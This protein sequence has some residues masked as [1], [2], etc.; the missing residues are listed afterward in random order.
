MGTRFTL[1]RFYLTRSYSCH[2]TASDLNHP[3]CLMFFNSFVLWFR[4][5]KL[6]T[7]RFQEVSFFVLFSLGIKDDLAFAIYRLSR[8]DESIRGRQAILISRDM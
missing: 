2:G 4:C 7:E 1:L 3:L 5:S 8:W 6:G